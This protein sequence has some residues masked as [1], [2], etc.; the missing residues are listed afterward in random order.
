[1]LCRVYGRNESDPR[2]WLSNGR[3]ESCPRLPEQLSQIDQSAIRSRSL[4][5]DELCLCI[6][7]IKVAIHPWPRDPSRG[8]RSD[9]RS[10][11]K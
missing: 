2:L 9:A 11:T 8:R 10:L 5:P 3:D 7:K 1:M 4:R 6:Q